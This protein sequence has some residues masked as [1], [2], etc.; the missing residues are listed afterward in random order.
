MHRDEEVKKTV[1]D[2]FIALMAD[3]YNVGIEKLVMCY[4]KCLNPYGD[5]VVKVK[6]SL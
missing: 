5:S 6:L 4:G 1:K 3:F 2:W